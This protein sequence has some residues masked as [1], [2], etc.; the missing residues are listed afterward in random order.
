VQ[1][2]R[3]VQGQRLEASAEPT[4]CLV[5]LRRQVVPGVLVPELVDQQTVR[6]REPAFL[7]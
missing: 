7:E 6:H 5:V 1:P 4:Q 2:I 3:L